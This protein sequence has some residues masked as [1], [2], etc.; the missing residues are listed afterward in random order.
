MPTR[1]E[2]VRGKR[3]QS[4]GHK[5]HQ[6]GGPVQN[7]TKERVSGVLRKYGTTTDVR[8]IPT[9]GL[10]LKVLPKNRAEWQTIVRFAYSFDGYDYW[11]DREKCGE[12][13]N[14]LRKHYF[15]RRT[16]DFSVEKLRTAL[17]FEARRYHHFGS[18]PDKQSMGYIRTIVSE[19]RK[20]LPASA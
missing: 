12:I 6:R 14:T 1:K 3:G 19:I 2:V 16:L 8:Q 17:F 20:R 15:E 7:S 18:A 10:T 13:G 11:G 9:S 5:A 4:G